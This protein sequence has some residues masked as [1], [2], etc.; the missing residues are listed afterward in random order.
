MTDMLKLSHKCYAC[1][2]ACSSKEKLLSHLREKHDIEPND[3][4]DINEG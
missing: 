2:S 4:G 3:E 1:R